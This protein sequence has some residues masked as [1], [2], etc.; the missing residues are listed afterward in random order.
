MSIDSTVPGGITGFVGRDVL[1]FYKR[2]TLIPANSQV[3]GHMVT[4]ALQPGQNRIGVVWEG[5]VLPNGH[6]IMLD[7]APGI[8]LTGTAGFAAA[9]DNH[10]RKEIVNVIAFSILAA[11][12][13]LAQPTNTGC[14]SN[15]FGCTRQLG[16]RLGHRLRAWARQRTTARRRSRP[17][18]TSSRVRKSAWKS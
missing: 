16:K 12:A 4:T 13:Q 1:D 5:I 14:N 9:I 15:G 11:G 7:A 17:R 10:T 3:V 18:H 2:V 6:E 8:D